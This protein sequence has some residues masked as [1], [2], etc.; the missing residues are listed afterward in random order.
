[1]G[2]GLGFGGANL[3]DT[4]KVI[5][6]LNEARECYPAYPGYGQ[7]YGGFCYDDRIEY[8]IRDHQEEN[9]LKKTVIAARWPA[10]EDYRIDTEIHEEWVER[11]VARSLISFFEKEFNQ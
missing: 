7:R 8:V 2:E 1:M 6:A 3:M 10:H 5:D 11:Q 4:Q 9:R